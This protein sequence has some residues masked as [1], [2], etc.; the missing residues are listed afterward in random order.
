MKSK[1]P[2]WKQFW[3]ES[4]MF[5]DFVNGP[6]DWILLR[7]AYPRMTDEQL[8]AAQE[9]TY[10]GTRSEE[11]KAKKPNYGFRYEHDGKKTLKDF[12]IENNMLGLIPNTSSI[13]YRIKKF[14]DIRK[15]LHEWLWARKR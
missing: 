11:K 13:K 8:L 1:A 12:F 9:A 3:F 2:E 7:K 10:G 15:L 4:N 5:F 6:D 14:L